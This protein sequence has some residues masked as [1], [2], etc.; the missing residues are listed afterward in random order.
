[1]SALH[2]ERE[3]NMGEALKLAAQALAEGEVP[4]GAVVARGTTILGRG[5]NQ[6]ESKKDP[7]AHAELLAIRQAAHALGGWRLTGCTLYVTLEPCPM[8]AGAITLAR[9]DAV[10]YG[11]ADPRAGCCGSVYRI[12]EDPVFSFTVPA[13]G[14][15]LAAEGRALLEEFFQKKRG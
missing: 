13:Y 10:W 7:T 12:T 5:C 15:L 3:A 9:L 6:R 2:T 4:V 14:G 1:M 11:A 8:C